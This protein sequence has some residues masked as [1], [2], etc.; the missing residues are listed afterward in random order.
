MMSMEPQK[1]KNQ[2]NKDRAQNE[3]AGQLEE[4]K[5]QAQEYLEGWKRTKADFINYKKEEQ[6]RTYQYRAYACKELIKNLLPILDSFEEAMKH[7]QEKE[8]VGMILQQMLGVLI[9]EGVTPIDAIHIP[10][11]PRIHE[12]VEMAEGKESHMVVE[13][14]QKGYTLHDGVL[15]VAK[16]KI[17]K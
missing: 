7:I 4:C 10:F 14:I 6:E 15:R 8:H 2:G 5:R 1:D 17:N 9:K 12:A 13:I 11:D 16:V 3:A